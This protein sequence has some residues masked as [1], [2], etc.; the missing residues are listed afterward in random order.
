LTFVVQYD[1]TAV[2]GTNGLHGKRNDLLQYGAQVQGRCQLAA[3]IVEQFERSASGLVFFSYGWQHTEFPLIYSN[4]EKETTLA[5]AVFRELPED[6][7][8]AIFRQ[9]WMSQHTCDSIV[10]ESLF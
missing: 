7:L 10:E 8:F 4:P 9:W 6:M 3:D 5:F 1:D 2:N